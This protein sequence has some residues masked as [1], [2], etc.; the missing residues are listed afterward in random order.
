MYFDNDLVT[1]QMN[2]NNMKRIYD[3]AYENI[4]KES[5]P[6]LKKKDKDGIEI[7]KENT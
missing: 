1:K 3:T 6:I 5:I 2:T 7:N 4:P